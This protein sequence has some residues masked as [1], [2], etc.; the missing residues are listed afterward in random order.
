[1]IDNNPTISNTMR[2][3][4]DMLRD[5]VDRIVDKLNLNFGFYAF[6]YSQKMSTTEIVYDTADNLLSSV[7]IILSKQFVNDKVAFY[8]R[9]IT[10]LPNEMKRPSKRVKIAD[11]GPKETPKAF[12]LQVSQAINNTFPSVFTIDMAEVVEKTVPKIEIQINGQYYDISG[13]TGFKGTI[14]FEN[15]VYRDMITR[16]K[17]K[18]KSVTLSLPVD[19]MYEKDR[20]V[21][22]D[23]IERCCKELIPYKETRVEIAERVLYPKVQNKIGIKKLMNDEKKKKKKKKEEE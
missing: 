12:A 19:E 20:E 23:G 15:V 1:M 3:H 8:V 17:V 4:Y 13:G 9:K 5:N 2:Y 22:L 7:G 21:I 18:G 6:R 11:C 16:K 10:R 14:I